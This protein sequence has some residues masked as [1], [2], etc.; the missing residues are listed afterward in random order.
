[1]VDA[2]LDNV[3]HRLAALIVGGLFHQPGGAV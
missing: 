2:L 1:M 3:D